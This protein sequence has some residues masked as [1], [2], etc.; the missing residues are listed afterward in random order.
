MSLKKIMALVSFML[1]ATAC[2][3]T[4]PALSQ[5]DADEC[6]RELPKEAAGTAGPKDKAHLT[7]CREKDPKQFPMPVAR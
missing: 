4:Q 2:Q 1:I 7:M 3:P 5:D 6:R